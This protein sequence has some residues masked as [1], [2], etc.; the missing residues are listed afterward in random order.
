MVQDR[1][2]CRHSPF[3]IARA[4]SNWIASVICAPD[5]SNT[6]K[7]VRCVK[8]AA[9]IYEQAWIT[10]DLEHAETLSLAKYEQFPNATAP[11][12]FSF[13]TR[14]LGKVHRV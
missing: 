12:S 2:G 1:A 11:M 3:A 10:L 8:K 14:S 9:L 4:T 7:A 5:D 13:L 6:P